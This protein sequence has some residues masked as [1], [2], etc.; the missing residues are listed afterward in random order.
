MTRAIHASRQVLVELVERNPTGQL[1][2]I[3]AA[4]DEAEGGMVAA[5]DQH[6]AYADCQTCPVG[7]EVGQR[8]LLGTK[9]LRIKKFGRT[10][11]LLPIL[12]GPFKI[13]KKAG[14][15]TYQFQLPPEESPF[16]RI[17][18]VFYSWNKQRARH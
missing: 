4:L 14:N 15:P 5:Q 6:K 16:L 9:C 2:R 8:V 12:I 18:D 3:H 11:K 13:L 1:S 17:Y 7:L 10:F